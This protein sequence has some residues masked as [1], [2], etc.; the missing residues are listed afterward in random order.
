MSAWQSI[1]T[2]P[3]DGTVV[4]LKRVFEGRLVDDGPGLFG[5]L[6]DAAPSRSGPGI[7]PLGRLTA[8]DYAEEAEAREAFVR[9][10][11]WLRADRMYLFP[12]PTHWMPLSDHPI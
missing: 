4:R 2:A 9:S 6:H 8:A 12:T 7:D 3:K 1:E 11:K 10:A 5:V